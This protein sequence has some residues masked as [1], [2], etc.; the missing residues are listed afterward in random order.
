MRRIRPVVAIIASGMVAATIMVIAKGM[1]GE[2]IMG[3]GALTVAISTKLI[4]SDEA[5]NGTQ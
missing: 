5:T 1:E 2:I 3:L 4:E